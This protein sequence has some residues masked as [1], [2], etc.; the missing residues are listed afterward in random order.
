MAYKLFEISKPDDL[1]ALADYLDDSYEPQAVIDQ[2]KKG[3][4]PRCKRIVLETFY[5]DKD[6]RSTYY[7]YYAK[8]GYRY[9]ISCARLHFFDHRVRLL[10][11]LDLRFEIKEPNEKPSDT[12]F[13][14]MVLRPTRENTIGRTVITPSAIAGFHGCIIEAN[15]KVHLLGHK[16]VVAGFPYMSQH[17]DISVC[18]HAACWTILRHYSERFSKYAEFL[19]YDIT[20]MA[21]E[22]DPGGLVPSAGLHV[23][24]A[25]R[26]FASAK[27]Y[28]VLVVKNSQD[29]GAFYSQLLAYVESGFPLFAELE[30]IGHAVAIIGHTGFGGPVGKSAPCHFAYDT[31]SGLVVVDDNLLPYHAIPRPAGTGDDYGCDDITAFIVPL[32]EKIYYP[33]EYADQLAII[34]ATEKHLGFD[35]SSLGEPIVRYFLTTTA[36]LRAFMNRCRS[37]FDPELLKIAMQLTL[38]QFVWLIEIA[39]QDQWKNGTIA[40]RVVVDATASPAEQLPIFLM[41]N[42]ERAYFWDRGGDRREQYVKL[43]SSSNAPLSRMDGEDGNLETH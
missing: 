35:H 20:R 18:A 36:H 12:Y 16:L 30:R 33:A 24:H 21:H 42:T 27:T 34:L 13:G 39:S 2:L 32:P 29:A 15:H 5:N 19:T 31:V 26:V 14:Y 40:T 6:Y 28:P 22:F 9:D 3:L 7:N 43:V 4:D 25:E 1:N 23:G 11:G 41:H 37:Q 38:P 10:D 8:K 17:A